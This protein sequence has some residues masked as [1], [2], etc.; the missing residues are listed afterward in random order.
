MTQQDLYAEISPIVIRIL[1]IS[2]FNS[3]ITMTSTPEW[4]SLAHVQLLSAIEKKFGI[5]VSPDHAF[6][7]TSAERLVQY[8]HATL[9][10]KQ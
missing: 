5:Q 6:K 4:D 9:K 1:Q 10:D 8:L 7:L 3:G 2:E